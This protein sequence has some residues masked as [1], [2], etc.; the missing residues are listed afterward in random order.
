MKVSPAAGPT[1]PSL[2]QTAMS[3]TQLS[4][5]AKAIAM[6]QGAQQPQQQATAHPPSMN[7]NN[8]SP[9]MAS[10][11]I[12]PTPM[13]TSANIETVQSETEAP[14]T[15]PTEPKSPSVSSQLALLSRKE[16]AMRAK[17]Q[18]QEAAFRQRETEFKAKEAELEA[19]A[20]QYSTGYIT[21]NQL[22]DQTLQSLAEAGVT[23]EDLTNQILQQSQT[24][25]YTEVKISKLEAELKRLAAETEMSKK[26]AVDQ[27]QET[28][29][30]ARRQISMDVRNLVAND[31]TYETIKAT[32]SLN[33]VTDLVM[34]TYEEDGYW[35]SVD[36]AA[37]EV[38]N[39]LIDEAVKLAQINKVRNRLQPVAKAKPA[40]EQQPQLKKQPQMKTLT[41]VQSSSRP[42]TSR[43]R[44]IA[45][46]EGRLK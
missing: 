29:V 1:P 32:R 15:T 11:V 8:I 24:N 31:P 4:A 6:V 44:A 45:A 3:Q 10:A 17:Q 40:N 46:M 39:Y 25:P 26:A 38:E 2:P 30:A 37:L 43:E 34:K 42:L 23:Y 20:A 35:M 16:K 12:P 22:K 36:D 21:K 7:Q 18:Q 33:D 5:R 14:V 41:N 27:Q 28:K 9:E 13:D 19:K